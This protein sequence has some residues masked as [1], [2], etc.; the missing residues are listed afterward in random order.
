MT[1]QNI[2]LPGWAARRLVVAVSLALAFAFTSPV[3]SQEEPEEDAAEA[4]PAEPESAPA[5]APETVETVPVAAEE[6]AEPVAASGTRLDAIEVTGSR[7]KRTDYETAQPV[8]V[9]SREDIERSGMTDINEILRHLNVAGNNSVTPAINRAALSLGEVSLDLRNLGGSH[10]LLLVN[11]RRWVTGLVSTQPNVSDYNTIPTSII[12]RVEI[13]K[14][15]AS[16]IYGSDAIGGVVNVITRKDYEGVGIDYQIGGFP[17]QGD[18]IQ[19][20]LSLDWGHATQGRSAFLN[21]SYTTQGRTETQNRDFTR[22]PTPAAGKTRW[23]TNTERGRIVFI[24]TPAN[25]SFYQCPNLQGPIAASVVAD[26]FLSPILNDTDQVPAGLQLCTLHL[27][28]GADG[29]DPGDYRQTQEWVDYY[30]RYKRDTLTQ[31]NERTALFGQITQ[32]IGERMSFTFESLYNLRRSIGVSYNLAFAGGD[33]IDDSGR[34]GFT[35]DHP[36]NPFGQAVGISLTGLDPGYGVW[37]MRLTDDRAN[38]KF[39]Q[40]VDTLRLG[41]TLRGNFELLSQPVSW[42]AGYIWS[43]NKIEEIVPLYRYDRMQRQIGNVIDPNT[44]LVSYDPSADP[45]TGR[46]RP[47][48][49][50]RGQAGFDYGAVT[51]ATYDTFQRNKGGQDIYFFDV[52]SELP[53][54]GFLAGP[55]AMATGLEVRKDRYESIIDPVIKA[56]DLV[57]INQQQDSGGENTS[58]EAYIEFGLPL[59]KDLPF[60]SALDIDLAG[61]I[62]RY[63]GFG[64]IQTGKAGIRWQP[65]DDL[66]LRGTYSTGFRAPSI[67]ELFLPAAVSGDPMTDPCAEPTK[68]QQTTTNCT[69]DGAATANGQLT[70]PYALWQGDRNLK[71]EESI[72]VTY[73]LIYS[74]RFVPDLNIAVDFYKITIDQY[75]TIGGSLAQYFLDSCYKQSARNYCNFIN[76]TDEGELDYVDTPYFNLGKI[77]TSGVDVEIDYLLPLPETLGRFKWTIGASYLTEYNIYTPQPGQPDQVDGAVGR[78]VP[79]G[80]WPRVKAGTEILWS[81]DLW[82]ASWNT[83]MAYHMMEVCNDF[84]YQ[85][86]FRELGLCSHPKLDEDGN[87]VSE[88]ELE[89]LFYHNLRVARELPE[90]NANIGLGINNVLDQNPPQSYSL[91]GSYYWFNYD[92]S[93]YETPGRFA[94][95]QVGFKF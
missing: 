38:L 43:Q 57:G 24:P 25:G 45:C 66:L 44:G 95:L 31:P 88:N 94:Y 58:E 27:I 51:Y 47:I 81:R 1:K 86:S 79:F 18:G 68:T 74:P 85:P 90:W 36:A 75:I 50:F 35:A 55:I 48:D 16:A 29:G 26:P 83:R 12:E 32:D 65:V 9:L 3:R 41:G 52:G 33:A 46:C 34:T 53:T 59:L 37:T 8:V 23:S 92:P 49:P 28:P 4:L 42:D 14:D 64:Q 54:A 80:G 20:Q 72:N 60:A 87:D 19:Q 22:S 21:L 40:A 62:S 70:S 82:S 17:E 76:R 71:P 5:E 13:L 10:T 61:R 63:P 39:Q 77:E 2:G 11:G 30:N 78:A 84:L 69:Q 67:A 73:G 6:K 15:G 93:N 56:G 91:I 7:L 89:T